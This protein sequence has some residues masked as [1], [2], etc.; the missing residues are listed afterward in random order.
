MGKHGRQRGG[1]AQAVA[2]GPAKIKSPDHDPRSQQTAPTLAASG[3]SGRCGRESKER[4]KLAGL[5]LDASN[6]YMCAMRTAR[7]R[8]S[9]GNIKQEGSEAR[10]G[11]EAAPVARGPPRRRPSRHWAASGAF[12]RC[13]APAPR[14]GPPHAVASVLPPPRPAP[15]PRRRHR[16]WRWRRRPYASCMT[17]MTHIPTR[18]NFADT[19]LRCCGPYS[20]EIGRAHV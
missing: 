7:A 13:A 20:A 11:G 10:R 1:V 19:I 12:A 17:R 14:P 2:E 5:P 3:P 8:R 15:S 6:M 16:H 9:A 4:G 18:A